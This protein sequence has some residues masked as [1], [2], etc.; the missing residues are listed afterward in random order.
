MTIKWL[1]TSHLRHDMKS[2]GT[3]L[4]RSRSLE[5]YPGI[6]RSCFE[7]TKCN[8]CVVFDYGPMCSPEITPYS[9]D[10]DDNGIIRCLDDNILPPEDGPKKWYEGYGPGSVP[11]CKRALC[12]CDKEQL[13]GSVICFWAFYGILNIISALLNG[14]LLTEVW[15]VRFHQFF[16]GFLFTDCVPKPKSKSEPDINC[17]GEYPARNPFDRNNAICCDGE[18]ND[19]GR[20]VNSS[21]NKKRK[22]R[23]LS[24]EEKEK[25]KKQK[26][27][28]WPQMTMS[29][30]FLRDQK[31]LQLQDCYLFV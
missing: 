25:K 22:R 12:E 11:G 21:F 18:I 10:F 31:K 30:K 28:F 6:F 13:Y 15:N 7:W 17:C 4:I 27:A 26:H 16:G 24:P 9:W 19:E 20:C 5:N 23:S 8:R 1:S 29:Q 14:N 3:E 2:I